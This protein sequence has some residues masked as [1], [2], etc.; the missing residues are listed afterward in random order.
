MEKEIEE[1][2]QESVWIGF[3]KKL[4]RAKKMGKIFKMN[5]MSGA[6]FGRGEPLVSKLAIFSVF[7]AFPGAMFAALTY[8][9]E[10]DPI[11]RKGNRTFST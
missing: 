3:R 10:N 1:E 4:E 9:P 5:L 8:S 11:K 6:V 2:K 7:I